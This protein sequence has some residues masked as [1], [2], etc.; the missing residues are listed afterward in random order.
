MALVPSYIK[1]LDNYKPGKSIKEA[2]RE[3]GITDF[4]K[5]ASNENPLGPSPK[6]LEAIK[7]SFDRLHRYPDT[8]GYELRKKLSER[9]NVKKEKKGG[10]AYFQES[11]SFPLDKRRSERRK[12][13]KPGSLRG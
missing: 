3:L 2:K 4:I 8:I 5:L 12:W 7:K 6:G 10:T 9:F 11:S 13:L 1:Q